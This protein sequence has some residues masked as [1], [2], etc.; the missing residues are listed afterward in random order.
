MSLSTSIVTSPT[1][2]INGLALNGS[3]K[4]PRVLH[5]GKF[6]P[7]HMGGIETH[8]RGLCTELRKSLDV[9]VIV[10]N[11]DHRGVQ[12]ILDGV[13]VSRMATW[14]TVASSPL[15]P[16]IIPRLRAFRGD[17]VHLHLPNPVAVLAYLA[18]GHRGRLVSTYHSDTI[19]QR[20]LGAAF[21]PF[22][23]AALRRSAA[24]ITTSPNY[25]ETSSVLARHKERCHVIPL[26]VRIEDFDR[27]DP[28]AVSA[29]RRQYG[30]RLIVSVGRL[31][32]YK[33]FE[34]L[35]RAMIH[36]QGNLV[37]V[38][39]G[40]LHGSL[41]ALASQLGVADR[42]HFLGNIDHDKLV[43]CHHAAKVFVLPSV[44]RSEAFG[45]V[46]VEAM[47]AGL[48]V[49]N[50]L[51]DSGVPFVSLHEQ[52]GLTV[53]PADSH[54][55]A[56]AINRLLDNPN[57]GQSLGRAARLRARQEFSL[58]VMTSRTLALY[59]DVMQHQPL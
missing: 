41:S 24:I 44:L 56:A 42:V 48:P 39:K 20:F 55:L 11:E 34:H 16:G 49:V 58:E 57:L 4:G 59:G 1:V 31:V 10:A 14:L 43:A 40:P 5:V 45:I 3:H 35:V 54:A 7:P 21:E 26:G 47:A 25:L 18:S 28:D 19:R 37:I 2:N 6:Y 52:T 13:P 30:E 17:I 33:G 36:V 51:L 22:L 46:Q 15:C 12:E 53:P 8:L 23:H 50:T 9:E 38:G 29:V 27:C 32:S